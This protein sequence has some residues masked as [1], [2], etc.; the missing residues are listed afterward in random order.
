MGSGV[1]AQVTV[2]ELEQGNG[3]VPAFFL[4]MNKRAG[5][6]DERFIKEAIGGAALLQP[7]LLQDFVCLEK[8]LLIE[9]IKEA[10]VMRIELASV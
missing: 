8:K 7:E 3:R 10:K 1:F 4:N 2:G 5:E 6:L 9:A